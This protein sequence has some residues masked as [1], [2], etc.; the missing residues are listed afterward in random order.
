MGEAVAMNKEELFKEFQPKRLYEHKKRNQPGIY[1]IDSFETEKLYIGSAINLSKRTWG[2]HYRALERNK[3]ANIHLQNHANKYGLKDLAFY[4]V[5]TCE[6]EELVDFEQWFLDNIDKEIQ[7]NISL[8]ADAPLRGRKRSEESKRKQ[9][10]TRKG[11]PRSEETRRKISESNKGKEG[12]NRGKKWTEE[13]KR[14]MSEA[15]KG[16]PSLMKGKNHPMYGKELSEQH[17]QNISKVNKGVPHSEKTKRK[18]A[19]TNKG[20]NHPMYGKKQSE[21]QKRKTF[22]TWKGRKHSEE[23]KRKMSEAKQKK[24]KID[25]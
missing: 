7:F 24:N 23:S 10:E 16:K 12:S 20:E 1:I 18:I 8:A 2:G 15:K 13:T 11:K 17:K 25:S 5:D 6:K 14:K 19:E 21:K 3:H 9:S 4:I 22:E